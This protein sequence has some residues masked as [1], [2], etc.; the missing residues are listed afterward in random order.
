M[1]SSSNSPPRLMTLQERISSSKV[2]K[3][4]HRLPDAARTILD[5]LQSKDVLLRIIARYG[6]CTLHIPAKWPP[7]G[8]TSSYKGHPLRKVLT[9]KQMLTFVQHYGGTAIYIPS[10]TKFSKELRNDVIIKTFIKDTRK[11]KSSGYVVEKL[12]RRYKLSDRRIWEILKSTTKD[13]SLID[14]K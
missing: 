3:I 12:A 10:C 8:K 5:I 9:P 6:G 7:I 11:G 14:A 4:Y 13:E 2:K 1:H